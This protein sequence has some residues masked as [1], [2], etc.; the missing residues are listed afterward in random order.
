MNKKM[1]T[2]AE[3]MFAIMFIVLMAT[4]FNTV[5]RF[6]NQ[7]NNMI[8]NIQQSIEDSD[9]KAYDNAIISGDAVRSLIN[10]MKETRNGTKMSYMVD[11]SGTKNAYGY[12]AVTTDSSAANAAYD[13][14]AQEVSGVYI[15]NSEADYASYNTSTE[16]TDSSFINPVDQYET[17]L[18][19]NANGI[20]IGI[21]LTKKS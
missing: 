6:G 14:S 9:L 3:I 17:K 1:I 15:K 12:K 11:I 20:A 4:L 5:T 16:I 2:I 7:A 13:S 8:L 18:I 19:F 21:Q 10:G